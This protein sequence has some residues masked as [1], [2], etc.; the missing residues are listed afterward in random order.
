MTNARYSSWVIGMSP[1]ST[2]TELAFVLHTRAFSNT[3]LII[4]VLTEHAGRLGLLAKGARTPKSAFYGVLQPF[5]PL[6]LYFGGKGE[7]PTLYKAEATPQTYALH[8]EQLYHGLYLNEL[9]M[10]LLHRH[11]PHPGVFMLYRNTLQALLNQPMPDVSL[12]YFEMQLLEELGYGLNLGIDINSGE[13]I[14]AADTYNY[15]VEQGPMKQTPAG[16]AALR[17]DGATLLALHSRELSLPAQR[18]Q[19]KQLMR[20]VLDQY[21]GQTP[22]KTRELYRQFRS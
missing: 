14:R 1:N 15:V 6:F 19:A 12:R 10:R 17:V 8:H 22:I 2:H 9:L 16:Q 13:P 21:L 4:E 5:I 18:Q 11:D 3:S 20:T 7:L